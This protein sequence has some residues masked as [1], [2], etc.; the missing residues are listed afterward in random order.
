MEKENII[1]VKGIVEEVGRNGVCRVRLEIPPNTHSENISEPQK[2]RIV[3]GIISGKIRTFR[4]KILKG[5]RVTLAMTPYD[6]TKGRIIHREK[7][8][9][10]QL[11][12][13]E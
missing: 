1:E 8:S 6:L 5:D 3:Q 11:P 2:E 13:K 7:I 4:I 9:K 10:P 12:P